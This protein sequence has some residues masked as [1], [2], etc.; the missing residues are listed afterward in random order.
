VLKPSDLPGKLAER[1]RV[2][3]PAAPVAPGGY[4]LW[5]ASHALRDTGNPALDT[6]LYAAAEL[7]VPVLAYAGLHGAHPYASDRHHMF[8]LQ[9]LR[10]WQQALAVRGVAA[11]VSLPLDGRPGPLSSLVAHS[12]LVVVDEMPVPPLDAWTRKL[13]ATA[14]RPV[15]AVDA[16]CIVPMQRSEKAPTR[17]FEFRRRFAPEYAA[18]IPEG[19]SDASV[20]PA[21]HAEP[22]AGVAGI[23]LAAAD[24]P[25][26]LARCA[27]DH[28]VPPVADTPGGMAAGRARWGAFLADGLQRYHRDRNDA[29]LAAGVS[30][31]S[32]YLHYGC[33][34]PFQVAREAWAAGGPGA[35]KFLDELLT[36]RELAH[37]F[38]F[39]TRAPDT[40]EALPA[41]ARETLAA[42]AADS[43]PRLPG[44]EA[45]AR[46]RSGH[47]LW[48]LAQASLL[49]HGEL[50][51]NLRM[52]WGKALA[53]W[54][55]SPAD[56]LATLVDLNH[57]YALDGS[58]PN[59]YGGLLWC[60]GQFD[61]P[62]PPPRP[63][64]GTVRSRSLEAHAARL[65]TAA[66][67]R[68]VLRASGRRL[69]VA[70]I[71][72]GAAGAM[73]ARTLA[74][75]GHDVRVF[76]KSRGAGGRMATRRDQDMQ[77][78]HGAQYITLRDPR[79]AR[80][81]D[82]WADAGIIAPWRLPDS[83]AE[84]RWVAVPGMN[85]LVRHLL[86]Q[87]AVRTQF[88]VEALERQHGGWS[89]AGRTAAGSLEVVGGFDAAVVA[90]PAP[91]AAS[92]LAG[93][94]PLAGRLEDAEYAPCWAVMAS[95]ID[96]A[97]APDLLR[98]A[99]QVCAHADPDGP[100]VWAAH[101]SDK[102]GRNG[103]HWVL[104]AGGGWSHARL[105][106]APAEI[107]RIMW[108]AF[109]EGAGVSPALPRHLEAHRWRYARVVR[110]LDREC[111]WDE[112]RQLAA[113]GDYCI[114]PRV[115]A[116]LLSGAAAAGRVMTWASGA[117]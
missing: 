14:A 96:P 41:W 20:A 22:P 92:L 109:T 13:A 1:C 103:N 101:D 87:A 52:S 43:R 74:D 53:A 68:H 105:E 46:A 34:S 112:A 71:G 99:R 6:A 91:Q 27:I 47:A 110:S 24:L 78:D 106:R 89:L 45:L 17:A 94:T 77:F 29:A 82:A 111:L 51:N 63:V 108:A 60:L 54:T 95:G 117:R 19:W 2:L 48:D 102:P 23:D 114:G 69:S 31:I 57:R 16:R 40:L 11:M 28:A 38:C 97:L 76:E 55:P 64:L 4:V 93:V 50:H 26:L 25:E 9:S 39:H 3:D 98:A 59:S 33:L 15:W 37:H 56:A 80:L 44:W 10:E 62:F 30:R 66:L 18:R 83:G 35:E 49:R 5:W 113:C 72:A 42:H 7:G 84:R 104:Q 36:W 90:L 75:Q 107:A 32:P 81:R 86:D 58:D 100:L 116:A 21:S 115:E 61:R 79:L 85:A 67:K 65:D 12:R 73:A 88:T 70:V 8:I